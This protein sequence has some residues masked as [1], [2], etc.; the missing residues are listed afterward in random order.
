MIQEIKRNE[1]QIATVAREFDPRTFEV[2]SVLVH[3][4]VTGATPIPSAWAR[5]VYTCEE[6]WIGPAPLYVPAARPDGRTFT[7]CLSVSE[8]GNAP[9]TS[10]ISYGVSTANLVG[11]FGP[12]RIPDGTPV[13]LHPHRS[14]DGTLIWLI[15]NTQAIDGTCDGPGLGEGIPVNEEPEE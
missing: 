14:S 3:A 13:T 2:D 1:R 4:S 12:V 6:I 5:W 8:N 10:T 11:S 15:V 7:P 9:P